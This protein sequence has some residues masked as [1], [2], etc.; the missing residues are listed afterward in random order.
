MHRRS[1]QAGD[2]MLAALE[3]CFEASILK[4]AGEMIDFAVDENV[5]STV[6]MARA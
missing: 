2:A 3:V 6:V 1:A 5:K 4:V